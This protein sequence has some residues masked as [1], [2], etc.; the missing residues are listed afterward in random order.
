MGPLPH[1]VYIAALVLLS[2]GCGIASSGGHAHFRGRRPKTMWHGVMV[3]HHTL[4]SPQ[5][6]LVRRCSVFDRRDLLV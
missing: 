1:K 4:L 2:P 3:I 6:K 5:G